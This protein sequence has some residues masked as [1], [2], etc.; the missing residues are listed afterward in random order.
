MVAAKK[1]FLSSVVAAFMSSAEGVNVKSTEQNLDLNLVAAKVESLIDSKFGHQKTSNTLAAKLQ[2]L[3]KLKRGHRTATTTSLKQEPAVLLTSS[4]TDKFKSNRS[5]SLP[6]PS[7]SGRIGRIGPS[8][9][10]SGKVSAIPFRGVV[11]GCFDNVASVSALP[12]VQLVA[13]QLVL[14]FVHQLV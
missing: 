8:R 13:V 14:V 5:R 2:E 4:S 9:L 6:S 7:P 10:G 12:L 3:S 11:C 1:F